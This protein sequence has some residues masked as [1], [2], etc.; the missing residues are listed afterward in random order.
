LGGSNGER[1]VDTA[2][3]YDPSTGRWSSIARMRSANSFMAATTAS[4]GR[5]YT[6]GGCAFVD[7]CSPDPSA[8]VYD[9]AA[10]TWALV[11]EMDR[12]RAFLAGA[13]GSDGRISAI[14]GLD[15]F[16]D[17]GSWVSAYDPLS[18]AWSEVAPMPTPRMGLAAAVGADGTIYA[19]GGNNHRST[20]LDTVEA[21]NPS[22]GTWSSIVPMPT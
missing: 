8:S 7:S 16:G 20:F 6:F 14:G 2:E 21:F 1:P 5:I 18:D 9:P 10:D 13:A 4:D 3:V 22:S 19:V 15:F 12:G 11:A 17:I